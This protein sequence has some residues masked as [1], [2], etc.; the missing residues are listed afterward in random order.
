M[1]MSVAIPTYESRGRGNEFLDDLFRT[2]EIQTFKNF[3]V[4]IS[5]HSKN[6]DLVDVIDKFQNK[7]DILYFKNKNDRGNGP[8]NT[9]NAIDKCSGDII[10]IMFQDDFFY[11]DEALQKIHDSFDDD[12]DWLVCGSNHTQDDGYNFYWD[13]Y[14][15]WNVD[16][17]EG[18]NSISSPSVMAA[19]KKVF[20]Q[21]KFDEKLVM[22]MDCE[23]YYHI[24]NKFGDPIYLHDIL[25]SNRIHSEQI[26]SEY[27]S[28]SD[29]SI[30]L[31][32]EVNYC[33]SKHL[34]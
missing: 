15:K 34:K 1:R 13:L 31:L 17:I 4:V 20:D 18:V 23:I 10:K 7:F 6:D 21:I 12:H 5:D 8:A 30:K 27:A 26:S 33:K 11:D 25:V 14:P 16:I 19:R 2:L 29:Y 9:N 28:S 22:M 24:K 32:K 3:E